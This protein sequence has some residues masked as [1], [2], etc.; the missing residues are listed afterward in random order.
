MGG[1]NSYF[2]GRCVT[3]REAPENHL[4]QLSNP[5]SR[6]ASVIGA[7]LLKHRR[8]LSATFNQTLENGN[9]TLNEPQLPCVVNQGNLG[10][11][12]VSDILY[13]KNLKNMTCFCVRLIM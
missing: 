5:G 10:Y 2:I 8:N 6:R 1:V 12:S 3:T 13:L 4:K 11:T 7:R 9:A